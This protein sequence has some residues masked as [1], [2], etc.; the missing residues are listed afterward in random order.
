MISVGI[1]G[2]AGYAAGELIR[3]LLN[4]PYVEISFIHSR[5]NAGE[6]I[7]RVHQDLEGDT[8]LRFTDTVNTGV[9]LLFLC[10]GHGNAKPFLDSITLPEPTKVIDL[11]SDFRLPPESNTAYRQP[12]VYGLPELNRDKITRSPMISN[13]GCFATAIQLALLPLAAHNRLNGQVHVHAITGSTGA[14]QS[15]TSTTHFSW[16]SHNVSIY[17][18][19]SHRH[20]D[21][22]KCSLNQVDRDFNSEINFIPVRGSFTRGIYATLYT[23]CPLRL[24][25]VEDYYESFYADAPFTHLV[26]GKL[27]LKQVVNTNKCL[28]SVR[29]FE[30]KLLICSA[31][32]NLVKGASG[33]A[34]QNM[35]LMFGFP[36]TEGLKLKPSFF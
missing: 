33:Q 17:N 20:L 29:K 31:I 23:E 22:I 28:V 4:H 25:E 1:I 11:S 32:D 12:F 34:V 6:A 16:R 26:N 18:P 24:S 36:E 7:T 9:D 2:G 14:G 15:L 5:S 27:H 30:N 13:P 21:E 35:N 10:M 3:I 8:D 19:F